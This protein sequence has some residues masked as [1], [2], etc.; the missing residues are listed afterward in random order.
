MGE[1]ATFDQRFK[2]R[3]W[4]ILGAAVAMGVILGASE[5]IMKP[6]FGIATL[7]YFALAIL[8]MIGIGSY[9]GIGHAMG[10]FKLGEFKRA[11]R[12]QDR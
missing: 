10:A 5:A 7:R 2:Q 12:R 8:I 1:A 9:F 6:F 4:R 3:I 11:L